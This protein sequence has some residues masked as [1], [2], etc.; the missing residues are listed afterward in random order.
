[1]SV[2]GIIQIRITPYLRIQS[3]SE[4]GKMWARITSN[5]DNSTQL[6]FHINLELWTETFW[7]SL[8]LFVVLPKKSY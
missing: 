8:N 6:F 1:M 5:T 4:C 3:E 7:K 2:F